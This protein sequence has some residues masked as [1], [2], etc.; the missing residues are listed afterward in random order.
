MKTVLLFGGSTLLLL[1]CSSSPDSNSTEN[2]SD[3]E[4][5]NRVEVEEIE[6]ERDSLAV[7][8]KSDLF[9]PV[10]QHKRK[11]KLEVKEIENSE[12]PSSPNVI[13]CGGVPDPKTR[14]F[15]IVEI[16]AQFPGGVQELKKFIRE[17]IRYPEE[18]DCVQGAVYVSMVVEKDG[19]VTHAEV[20]RGGLSDDL[21]QEALRLV[22]SMPKWIPAQNNGKIIA[23]RVR[24]PIRF[25]LN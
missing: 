13:S 22:R 15:D 10:V 4:M 11:A 18:G 8:Q 12:I 5:K 2:L 6:F 3:E 7:I 24:L 14:V 1:S 16:D 25:T 23:A 20:M 17:N 19:C 21:N 9:Q